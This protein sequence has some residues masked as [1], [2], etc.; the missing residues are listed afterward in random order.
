M[1]ND[2]SLEKIKDAKSTIKRIVK[3]LKKYKFKFMLVLLFIVA[4]ITFNTLIS[5]MLTPILL[6]K[7]YL[8]D[9]LSKY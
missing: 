7:F 1:H 6:I 9:C 5:L 2:P 3:Y 4:Y 8:V